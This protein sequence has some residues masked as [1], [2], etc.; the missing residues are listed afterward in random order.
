MSQSTD[1]SELKARGLLNQLNQSRRVAQLISDSLG[2][3]VEIYE[4]ERDG[5][6]LLDVVHPVIE[7]EFENEQN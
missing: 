6:A 5:G 1:K 3:S 7:E 2:S 4:C